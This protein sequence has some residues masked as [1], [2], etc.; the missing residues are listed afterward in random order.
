MSIEK[1]DFEVFDINSTNHG[2]A[3]K[4]LN[5]RR[6]Y[7]DEMYQEALLK[8][9]NGDLSIVREPFLKWGDVMIGFIAG[10]FLTIVILGLI[11]NAL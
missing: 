5:G 7:N 1:K 4:K 11:F 9:K 3:Y 2:G 10:V 8:A 6:M